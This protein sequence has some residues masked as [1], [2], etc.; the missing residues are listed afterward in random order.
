MKL[1]GFF[2]R[3]K[4]GLQAQMTFFVTFAVLIVSAIILSILAS[5]FRKEYEHELNDRFSEAIVATTQ[6]IEQ[7]MTNMKNATR[8]VTELTSLQ[9]RNRDQ[10]DTILSRSLISMADIQ[11]VAITLRKGYVSSFSDKYYERCAWYNADNEISLSTFLYDENSVS[12]SGWND[13]YVEGNSGWIGPFTIEGNSMSYFAYYTPLCDKSNERI[14]IAYSYLRLSSLTSMVTKYKTRK[15]IDVSIYSNSGD[16]IVPPDDY[17]LEL[18][19][20]EMILQERYIED[21]GWKIIFS[22][23][24][25]VIDG[26]IREAL[27][28]LSLLIVFLFLTIS[29]S[30]MLTVRYVAKPFVYRQQQTEKEKAVMDNEMQLAAGVQKNLVPH[31]FPPFPERNEIDLHACLY[32]A[33]KVGGDMYD[34]FLQ[35]DRLYFCI[36]DVSGKGVQSS[37]LM[38]A[39]HYLFRSVAA[40]LPACEAV[41]R[42]NSS[43]CTDNVQ[44]MF[45]TFWYGCLDLKNGL[46]EYVNAGHNSPVIV[47]NNNAEYM[48]MAENMPLGVMEEAEFSSNIIK[49]N[50]ED[51][52]FLYTDGISE[53]MDMSNNEFGNENTL[54]VISATYNESSS[55][56]ID[57]VLENVRQH[58]AGTT[59]SDDITML[60]LKIRKI[61]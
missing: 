49:L 17:I 27:L 42:I 59:Q 1:S 4:I 44:C 53:A 9:I 10:I 51:L 6:F 2:N 45:A 24:R 15:D 46:L 35:N 50:S 18:D 20:D 8:T 61:Q 31:V 55:V 19:P 34:Y 30:I 28:T 56:I 47:R 32:P 16:T 38:A 33:R 37:L 13:C 54:A 40:S 52:L 7:K 14:G 11:G 58:A 43:L 23:D 57:N 25:N 26:K 29:I 3:T 36:G 22:A 5:I 48:P 60:C 21:L 39:I 12:D 41:S